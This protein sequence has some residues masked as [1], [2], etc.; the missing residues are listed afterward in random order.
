MKMEL[1]VYLGNL[2]SEELDWIGE[3]DK[4][5][6]FEDV[7]EERQV[8]L[9]IAKLEG[10]ASPWSDY[11]QE[12]RRKKGKAKITSWDRMVAKLKGKFLPNDYVIQLYRQL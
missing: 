11:V 2:N 9:A 10:H 5:F 7:P 8:K 6:E 1:L 12:E 4:Y 3:L